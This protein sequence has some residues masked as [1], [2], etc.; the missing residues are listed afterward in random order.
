VSSVN[1][2]AAAAGVRVG[3]T[4]RAAAAVLAAIGRG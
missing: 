1:D 2:A 4:A 3:M